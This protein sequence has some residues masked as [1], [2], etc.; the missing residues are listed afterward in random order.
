[1]NSFDDYQLIARTTAR[2]PSDTG[3][4]YC[5]LGLNGEAG[6]VADQVKRIH[7]DDDGVLTDERRKKLI[8]ELGEI[9]WYLAN[10]ADELGVN[11][12]E[13]AKGNLDKL[14]ARVIRG[15]INGEGSDR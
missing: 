4:A 3:I 6:E 2:Y 15:R 9:L 1:M 14:K 10:L 5:A 12:S 7:R 8:A 11:L 13:V